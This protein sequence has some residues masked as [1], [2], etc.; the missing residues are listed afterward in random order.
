M[1][2]E[3][4]VPKSLIQA[5]PDTEITAVERAVAWDI[6][7]ILDERHEA[8]PSRDETDMLVIDVPTARLRGPDGRDDNQHL[9]RVL[10]RLAKVQWA[11]QEPDGRRYVVQLIGEAE[12]SAAGDTV[13]L[14]LPP[15]AVRFLRSPS[16]FAKL[17][18]AAAYSLP[19]NARALYGLLKDRFAQPDR[20]KSRTA[21][22]SLDE[23]KGHLQLGGRYGRYA[24]FRKWVLAPSVQAINDT[25][26][27]AIDWEPVKHGRAVSGVRFT[28][29]MK[30]PVEA[31]KADH[32]GE[33]HSK[34]RGKIQETADAPPLVVVDQARRWLEK[35]GPQ[36][37]I[38]WSKRAAEL[39]AESPTAASEHVERW[40][41]W[42]AAELVEAEGL[43]K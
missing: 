28:L 11:D 26:A 12:I 33:R 40:V 42:V 36:K 18:R 4:T 25:G 22:Y 31:D 29:R 3:L 10:K 38:K 37:R 30:K 14:W 23:L 7:T 27:L 1:R 41:S 35:Q 43:S 13:R 19:P 17:D 20:L 6:A 24:D 34:A 16:Q 21:E 8:A 39:G 32:E 2:R 5:Q 15:R 9:H